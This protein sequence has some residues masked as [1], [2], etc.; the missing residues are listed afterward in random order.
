MFH[1]K[2]LDTLRFFAFFLVFWQH[3]FANSFEGISTN[4]TVLSVITSFTFTGGEGVHIFF[5]IS[6]FLITFLLVKEHEVSGKIHIKNFYIRRIL[7]IW[8]LYY[9]VMISGIFVLPCLFNSFTFEGS[10]F[11]NLFFLNNFDISA[12][13]HNPNIG[14][15]WS[16]A[17]EEQFYI[18]WPLIFTIFFKK[19]MLNYFC[20]AMLIFSTI[21]L[22][23][24]HDANAY[25]H[26]FGNINFLMIGCLGATIYARYTKQ[27]SSSI[28]MK[29]AAFY[30]VITLTIAIVLISGI[31]KIS[32]INLLLPFNYLW[33]I[34]YLVV[35]SNNNARPPTI[36]S[37]WGKYTYGMYL[38]HPL[39]I[40]FVKMTFDLLHIDNLSNFTNTVLALISLAITIVISRFSYIYFERT[41]LKLKTRFST[42]VTRI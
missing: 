39:I 14:I 37:K 15:A 33:I 8:P 38:Y 20:L 7:R 18:F 27:I 13:E 4:K 28:L 32:F 42:V 16:V 24:S 41:F 30:V 10:V 5:V 9:L 17:I 22:Y 6:G 35:T 36:I 40:L 34:I 25:F 19:G 31:C 21:Y 26:T 12:T 11:K 29:N 3:G 23:T 2:K 1:F